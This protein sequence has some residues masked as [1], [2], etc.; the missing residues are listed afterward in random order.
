MPQNY[1][2]KQRREFEEEKQPASLLPLKKH[3]L[4][5]DDASISHILQRL[6]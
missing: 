4:S 3:P 1:S 5:P 6:D 2:N